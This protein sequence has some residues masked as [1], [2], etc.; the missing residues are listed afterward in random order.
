MSCSTLRPIELSGNL[1]ESSTVDHRVIHHANQQLL[2][3]AAA[4]LIDDLPD[5]A[6]GERALRRGCTITVTA[7]VDR[8]RN[9]SLVFE[10]SEDGSNRGF[11]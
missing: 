11:L 1:F 8:M 5:G 3:R 7:S 2:D 9:K 6:G 4:E 10:A